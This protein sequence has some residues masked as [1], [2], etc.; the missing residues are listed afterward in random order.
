MKKEMKKHVRIVSMILMI[1]GSLYL[2]FAGLVIVLGFMATNNQA[3]AGN[4]S[5]LSAILTSR[6]VLFSLI[7]L[8]V[9]HI[10]TAKAFRAEK[11]WSRIVLWILS[12]LN[13][14]NVP[15]GTGVAI[16]TIWVLMNTREDVVAIID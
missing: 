13:L 11:G 8:A 5:L 3:Q 12:V 15:V 2:L 4:V 6:T 1:L 10:V 9:V 14:G 7:V 16:Y